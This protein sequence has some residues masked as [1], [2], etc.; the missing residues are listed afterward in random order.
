[1][2][3][4]DSLVRCGVNL[5]TVSLVSGVYDLALGLGLLAGRGLLL[6]WFGVAAPVP[7]IHADLNGVFALAIAVGY[8]LPWRDPDRYRG[9]LWVMGPILKGVGAAWFVGDVLVRQSPQ[10]YLV[11]AA[12]DGSLALWTWLALMK[13]RPSGVQ[14]TRQVP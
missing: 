3:T 8:V 6:R 5:R 13:S 2:A 1:M 12:C 10:A 11:F 9:Y 4:A 7:A 14:H